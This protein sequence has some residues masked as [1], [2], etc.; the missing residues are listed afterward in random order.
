M[1]VF[2]KKS[3]KILGYCDHVY[4]GGI[5]FVR[6]LMRRNVG[7]SQIR[8]KYRL[9]A[10][11]PQPVLWFSFNKKVLVSLV[12]KN[13]YEA[14]LLPGFISYDA[15]TQGWKPNNLKPLR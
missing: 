12:A 11:F 5:Y 6:T 10:L 2:E 9:D 1:R 3:G 4:S 13:K 15:A 14:Q 7:I 8:Y